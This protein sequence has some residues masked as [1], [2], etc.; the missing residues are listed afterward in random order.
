MLDSFLGSGT[1]I[2]MFELAMQNYQLRNSCTTRALAM[3]LAIVAIEAIPAIM[4]IM[5]FIIMGEGLKRGEG[6]RPQKKITGKNG[7][8]IKI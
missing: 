3:A 1:V 8:L 7:S 4:P 5:G 6:P 2:E